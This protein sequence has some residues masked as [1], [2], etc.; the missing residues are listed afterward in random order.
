MHTACTDAENY[1]VIRKSVAVPLSTRLSIVSLADSSLLDCGNNTNRCFFALELDAALHFAGYRWVLQ[2]LTV[3]VMPIPEHRPLLQETLHKNSCFQSGGRG[4]KCNYCRNRR[5][6]NLGPNPIRYPNPNRCSTP[7]LDPNPSPNLGRSPSLIP[8]RRPVPSQIH[9][10]GDDAHGD[11][12]RHERGFQS[13]DPFGHCFEYSHFGW[14]YHLA[15]L[16]L[17]GWIGLSRR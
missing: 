11:D 10:N 1:S 9:P 4:Q 7:S 14:M 15:Q 5:F 12:V 3:W 6:P 2:A 8:V 17:P 16:H 13:V